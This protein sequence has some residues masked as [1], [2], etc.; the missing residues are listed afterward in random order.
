MYLLISKFI[1]SRIKRRSCSGKRVA[2]S[3]GK[4]KKVWNM[5][6]KNKYSSL[7]EKSHD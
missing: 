7:G 5:F 1:E 2:M 3:K 6:G 4:G